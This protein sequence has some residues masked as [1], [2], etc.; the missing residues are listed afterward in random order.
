MKKFITVIIAA[1]LIVA[2]A[3]MLTSCSQWDTPYEKLD[4]AGND[5]SVKFDVGD[6][7]FAGATT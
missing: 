7:M 5:V 3:M 2:A 4:E 1:T 6:G